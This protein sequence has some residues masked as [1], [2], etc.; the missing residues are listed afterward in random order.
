M[1]RY[2]RKPKQMDTQSERAIS[3]TMKML[4]MRGMLDKLSPDEVNQ[5]KV[6]LGHIALAGF[7]DAKNIAIDGIE[8]AYT[9]LSFKLCRP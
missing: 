5:V 4:S 3:T 7:M 6:N 8:K 9:E 2:S 1:L